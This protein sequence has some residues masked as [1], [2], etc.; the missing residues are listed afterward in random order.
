METFQVDPF[1]PGTPRAASNSSIFFFLLLLPLNSPLA[2]A[3]LE[4]LVPTRLRTLSLSTAT[5][6]C[7][8]SAFP[9]AS[10]GTAR[11]TS[12]GIL[13]WHRTTPAR[14]AQRIPLLELEGNALTRPG[15]NLQLSNILPAPPTHRATSEHRSS[16]LLPAQTLLSP[17]PLPPP[18][19]SLLLPRTR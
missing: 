10:L 12:F 11:Q 14:Q 9:V 13:P 15:L 17:E 2:K 19:P 18:P 8:T 1:L 4:Y 6:P 16:S 7:R 5:R 3:H